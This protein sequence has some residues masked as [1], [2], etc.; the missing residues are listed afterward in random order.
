[1][2]ARLPDPYAMI[3]EL[4]SLG[5][6]FDGLRPADGGCNR[7]VKAIVGDARKTAGWYKRTWRRSIWDFLGNTTSTLMRL[8]RARAI[9]SGAKPNATITIKA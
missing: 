8:I 5:I 3:A 6:V 2:P 9:T 7:T 1:M 4:K